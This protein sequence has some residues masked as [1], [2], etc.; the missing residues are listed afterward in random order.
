MS[1]ACTNWLE[2][3]ALGFYR[4]PKSCSASTFQM[5]CLTRN[6]DSGC[7]SS[8]P[9]P[10]HRAPCETEGPEGPEGWGSHGLHFC[11]CPILVGIVWRRLIG[12]LKLQ[13]MFR[14]KAPFGA[15]EPLI[16]GLFTPKG[17]DL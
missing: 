14:L 3:G 8:T 2:V 10:Q 13:V 12:C 15:K 16:I 11:V 6:P 1:P 17:N 9:I 4:A 7:S 5:Q